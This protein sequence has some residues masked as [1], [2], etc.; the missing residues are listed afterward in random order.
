MQTNNHSQFM[1]TRQAHTI[2]A[3]LAVVALAISNGLLNRLY[4]ASNHP[5]D[6]MTGQ[7]S[8]DADRIKGWYAAMSEAGTLDIYWATQLFDYVF[9]AS[10]AAVGICTA[11]LIARLQQSGSF[12]Q[13]LAYRASSL[14]VA[15]AFFDL[16]LIHI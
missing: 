16:S 3:V 12:G 8:F 10:V 2:A 5:V 7:T 15:G 13:R 9:I 6:Y 11:T 4:L 14:L 1:P